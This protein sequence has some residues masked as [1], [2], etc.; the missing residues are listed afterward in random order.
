[1]YHR[2]RRERGDESEKREKERA[3]RRNLK[4][5]EM[6]AHDTCPSV[7][8]LV[9]IPHGIVVVPNIFLEVFTKKRKWDP[10]YVAPRVVY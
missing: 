6:W 10:K 8:I 7:N 5:S 3:E 9:H 4:F 2:E 1:M